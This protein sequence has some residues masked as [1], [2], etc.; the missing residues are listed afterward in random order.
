MPSFIALLLF[1]VSLCVVV[2]ANESGGGDNTVEPENTAAP[3]ISRY[4]LLKFNPGEGFNLRVDVLVRVLLTMK[5]LQELETADAGSGGAT[6]LVLLPWPHMHHWRGASR[7]RIMRLQ[8][9]VYDG[10]VQWQRFFDLDAIR[11]Y[12]VPIVEYSEYVAATTT[13]ATVATASSADASVDRILYLRSYGI[14]EDHK[15]KFV[16]VAQCDDRRRLPYYV[17]KLVDDDAAEVGVGDASSSSS[18]SSQTVDPHVVSLYAAYGGQSR[19]LHTNHFECW[20]VFAGAEL[21]APFLHE[22]FEGRRPAI[23]VADD[24][25]DVAAAAADVAAAAVAVQ[26]EVATSPLPRSLLIDRPA[27]IHWGHKWFGYPEYWRVREVLAFA[28]PLR[29]RAASFSATTLPADGAYVA[30]HVRR[31]D[32]LPFYSDTTAPPLFVIAEQLRRAAHTAGVTV[33]FVA[34]DGTAEE[35]RELE[36]AVTADDSGG[37]GGN[38]L[39]L[40]A[41]RPDID[42][43]TVDA[44]VLLDAQV[45]IVDQIICV[46]ARHFIGTSPSTFSRGIMS[47]RHLAGASQKST[48]NVFCQPDA[49]GDGDADMTFDDCKQ[50]DMHSYK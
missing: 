20:S 39:R 35:L 25:D 2:A 37:G 10:E 41:F 8:H 1:F 50:A 3:R 24:D 19:L 12:G 4:V 5:H 42:E 44:D 28:A 47:R 32:Y 34:T 43:S 48:Y 46:N 27:T 15:S 30:A 49:I 17:E 45:A 31:A 13:T 38:G 23:V 33:V 29:A 14:P 36:H 7:D 11:A 18:S 9:E 6:A 21:L 40:L 22:M 26:G 16:R